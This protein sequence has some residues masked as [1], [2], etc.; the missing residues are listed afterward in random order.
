MGAQV[1]TAFALNS[2]GKSEQTTVN[3]AGPEGS[4]ARLGPVRWQCSRSRTGPPTLRRLA[5]GKGWACASSRL[6]TAPMARTGPSCARSLSCD[7]GVSA[8]G[9]ACWGWCS[10]RLGEPPCPADSLRG[11]QEGCPVPPT[12]PCATSPR[13]ER[14]SSWGRCKAPLAAARPLLRS[15]A[16]WGEPHNS[17]TCLASRITWLSEGDGPCSWHLPLCRQPF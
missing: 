8:P 2:R 3:S 10:C 6:G 1:P 11:L 17:G 4:S 9:C 16:V 15:E 13:R 5:P 14:F 12:S 7:R